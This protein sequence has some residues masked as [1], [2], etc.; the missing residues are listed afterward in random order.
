MNLIDTSEFE[1]E[2]QQLLASDWQ[3]DM[4]SKI[5]AD[6]E[7]RFAGQK[8]QAKSQIDRQFENDS[9]AEKER[10]EREMNNLKQQRDLDIQRSDDL[11][12]EQ[13]RQAII[14]E[15][16][17]KIAEQEVY[18]K[19]LITELDTK[20]NHDLSAKLTE[21]M[22]HYRPAAIA[23]LDAGYK[24]IKEQLVQDE[25]R[26]TEKHKQVVAEK[27][28]ITKQTVAEH[29]VAQMQARI[30]TL[31]ESDV[32]M[33]KETK[34]LMNELDQSN[35]TREQLMAE[36][37]QLHQRLA[38][39]ESKNATD[40]QDK[41]SKVLEDLIAV[42][43]SNQLQ[44]GQPQPK[45]KKHS[46]ATI[47]LVTLL[48]VIALGGAG[49]GVHSYQTVE[50]LKHDQAAALQAAK[51]E[52]KPK[53]EAKTEA[54]KEKADDFK[55]LDESLSQGSLGVY[56]SKYVGK[57]LKTD[58]RTYNVGLLFLS[59]GLVD[60]AWAVASSNDGH[61]ERLLALLKGQVAS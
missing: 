46:R 11:L 12:S 38:V 32:R 36:V 59:Q 35:K 23:S 48:S 6:I 47:A 20:F 34:D 44:Q 7:Q 14:S 54:T 17:Q 8:E 25:Q 1:A 29:D 10:H 60:D 21:A 2:K 30:S 37:D 27:L 19:Q 56:K 52:S 45:K 57:D 55:L 4:K 26:L 51:S 9:L 40:S 50:Q 53:E 24:Q 13:E 15:Q 31:S 5:A 39:A 28:E 42:Q 22:N 3:E 18:I 33:T 58:D 49:F 61:N 43:L 41:H 16:T